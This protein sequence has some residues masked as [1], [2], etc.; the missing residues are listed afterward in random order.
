VGIVEERLDRDR[1]MA[2][3][4]GVGVRPVFTAQSSVNPT[5]TAG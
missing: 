3:P 2:T 1:W 4:A 5:F